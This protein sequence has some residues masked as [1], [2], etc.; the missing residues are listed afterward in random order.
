MILC[1][2]D[3]LIDFLPDGPQDGGALRFAGH[4]GG[5][6]LNVARALARLGT[7]AGLVSG[8]SDDPFGRQIAAVLAADGV[9]TDLCPVSNRPTTLAFV[10]LSNGQPR[11]AFRDEG[12]AARLLSPADMP[13]VTDSVAAMV[14]GG[15][16]LAAEPCGAAFEALAQR[17]AGRTCIVLDPNVRPACIADETL[18]RARLDRMLAGA[19][20][21]KLSDEDL[22]WIAG[23][24]DPKAQAAALLDRGPALVV[25]TS[26]AGGAL[27]LTAGGR[28][29]MPAPVVAVVDTVGAGDGFLAGLL[30]GLAADAL[31]SRA[32]IAAAGPAALA[33]ALRRAVTVAALVCGRM[34]AVGPTAAE[35]AAERG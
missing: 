24:G 8:L 2:G 16:T 13:A 29:A 28:I 1:C 17:A 27:A 12:S 33:P 18:Y 23:P 10:S 34:G 9:S 19:D 22:G 6:A 30:S 14:F 21:V 7:A 35:V 32:A 4:P 11:F 31:L 3:A 25:L 5:A 26:G 15:V 20:I